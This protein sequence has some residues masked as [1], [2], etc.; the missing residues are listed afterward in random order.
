MGSVQCVTA[1]ERHSR[2]KDPPRSSTDSS[3]H[4]EPQ[5]EDME[6]FRKN[7]LAQQF[8]AVKSIEV[9][10]LSASELN[11]FATAKKIV[12]VVTMIVVFIMVLASTVVSKGATFLMVSQV[13]TSKT[14]MGFCADKIPYIYS[15]LTSPLVSNNSEQEKV[16]WLWGIFFCFVGP[17][18]LVFIQ[19]LWNYIARAE[20]V[21]NDE[22]DASGK[23]KANELYRADFL[24]LT[25]FEIAHAAGTA[26]LFVIAF[27][28][29]D[30]VRAIMATS[31]LCWFPGFLLIIKLMKENTTTGK[32]ML[33]IGLT[34]ISLLLQMSAI[35]WPVIWGLDNKNDKRVWALP[36]G[37][38][39][40]SLGWW[41]AFVGD[42]VTGYL[43]QLKTKL[44]DHERSADVNL[45]VAPLKIC[46]FIVI[47]MFSPSLNSPSGLYSYFI[48]SFQT[49]DYFLV[50]IQIM[51]GETPIYHITTVL[52]GVEILWK[53]PL[54]IILV[55]MVSTYTAYA[56]GKFACQGKIQEWCYALPLSLLATPVCILSVLQLC[57][58]RKSDACIYSAFPPHV[59]FHCP[60][61]VWAWDWKWL[62]LL[63]FLSQLWITHHIWFPK[64]EKLEKTDHIFGADLYSGLFI[65]QS[66]MLNRRSDE[67]TIIIKEERYIRIK[68][69]ATLWHETS[70]EM[71][72]MLQSTFRMD[73]WTND[74]KN[75]PKHPDFFD[76]ELHVFFDDAM[77]TKSNGKVVVNDFV[78]TLMKTVDNY[79]EMYYGKKWQLDLTK[80][81][82]P[83]GGRLVWQLPGGTSI[84]VHLKNKKKI[85]H[86][87]RWSQI[88]YIYYFLVYMLNNSGLTEEE[89]EDQKKNTFLLA[90]DGDVDFQPDAITKVVDLMKVNPKVGAACGRI[91]PTGTGPMQWYQKFE[92]AIGHWLQKATEHMLGCVLCSP[93]CFS[94]FRAEALMTN[95]VMHTYT[96]MA[97]EPKHL[98]Q[99]DQ[100][101]DR[102]LCT[103]MLKQGWRVEYSAAS[104]SFTQCPEG[105]KEFF[106]QRRRW[107]PS[108]MLN[109]VDLIGDSKMVVKN[110]PDI[111]RGYIFYQSFMMFG[112]V[113]GPGSIFLMLIGAFSTAFGISNDTALIWNAL[114]AGGFVVG[115]CVLKSPE[116]VRLAELLT[117][118]YAIIMIAVY[119]GIIL[120]IIQDG[121]ESLTGL[122]FFVTIGSF[123]FAAMIHPMEFSCLFCMPIYMATIP[124]MYMLLM[125]YAIFNI[126]DVSWGTREGPKS[127]ED[128]AQEAE[129]K[130]KKKPEGIFGFVQSQLDS[131]MNGSLSCICCGNEDRSEEKI[132]KI[133][134]SL[135][136]T[137]K[138]LT[139]L[140]NSLNLIKRQMNIDDGK[141]HSEQSTDEGAKT[142]IK[143]S[144]P[145]APTNVARVPKKSVVGLFK[146][147]V[148][149]LQVEKV[150][151]EYW[152]DAKE[153]KE[154]EKV[155]ESWQNHLAPKEQVFW[156]D[157]IEKFLFVEKFD[158][159]KRVAEVEGLRE[160][161]N[162][163]AGGFVL[164]NVMWISAFYMLQAHTYELG[165][166][167]PL[168]EK[169]LSLSWDTSDM[170]KQDQIILEYMYLKVDVLGMLF[171]IGFIGLMLLQFVTMIL[172]RLLTLE[173]IISST[174]LLGPIGLDLK[175]E[176]AKSK[177]RMKM[178][179]RK[180]GNGEESVFA[181]D[182]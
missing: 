74:M 179:G 92:Y 150:N 138:S 79:G 7:K 170:L 167:W 163:T 182:V 147:K 22:D 94:L 35:V 157:L 46:T 108:T 40:T 27:P 62:G 166:K 45:G 80:Y 78:L 14:P 153:K 13:S 69:C 99:Y 48:D 178:N 90:L 131:A 11:A 93:G 84:V 123:A 165:I 43:S 128:L 102:W 143:E 136:L 44:M 75:F 86:K 95:N 119:I 42:W 77:A 19:S 115:C 103:L 76:W 67:E 29:M 130:I 70:E 154:N 171:A 177:L 149:E 38:F 104:D 83:Y 117:V 32:K 139:S 133:Q 26:I 58:N 100:G 127:A 118:V 164:V 110:N 122:S 31:A 51:T 116:Q 24:I 21:V 87:K 145:S 18:F 132:E 135:V 113:F 111:S 59:F 65:D 1:M 52:E 151:L 159:K 73:D 71:T 34:A 134:K 2:N 176:L 15:N 8:E 82:T 144:N 68:G 155:I 112:T 66:L 168:G 6:D 50:P 156:K 89:K 101:E 54:M 60:D 125:I 114:L 37:L 16:A 64:N 57:Y 96:T 55:Q 169:L 106:N 72:V 175:Q 141:S 81:Q 41:E 129:E 17:E 152:K 25:F 146:S 53:G 98:V 3:L 105:F 97:T 124:S 181:T 158:E 12:K 107:M 120:Q 180:S 10:K 140:E 63:W 172:H 20:K 4:D 160:L 28:E 148:K 126:N 39:L 91:H 47:F 109:I 142:E 61:E 85:R 23:N 88:M 173:H 56:F 33:K 5:N 174:P 121:P 162:N 9:E 137:E 161:K 36:V 30:S 49:F